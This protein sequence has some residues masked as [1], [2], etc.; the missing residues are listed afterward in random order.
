M[1]VIKLPTLHVRCGQQFSM[2][3][4]IRDSDGVGLDFSAWTG[5]FA[6]AEDY[7]GTAIVSVVPTLSSAGLIEVDLTAVQTALLQPYTGCLVFQ[8]DVDSLD[9][10]DSHRG[11]GR[12]SIY[13]E[14]A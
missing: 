14:I 10:T 5:R 3:V 2:S 13:P 1:S 6:I 7:A 12:V 9:G 11:I 4:T 8:L